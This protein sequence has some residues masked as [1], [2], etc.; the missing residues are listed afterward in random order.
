MILWV[1]NGHIRRGQTNSKYLCI[2]KANFEESG[3]LCSNHTLKNTVFKFYS[4]INRNNLTTIDQINIL[5][6]VNLF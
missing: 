5:N 1:T 2:F 3:K 6:S 4:A